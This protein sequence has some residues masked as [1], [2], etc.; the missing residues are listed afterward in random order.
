MIA[1]MSAEASDT[2][3]EVPNASTVLA[4]VST[5]KFVVEKVPSESW[6]AL[7]AMRIVGSTRKATT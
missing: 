5:E 3:R 2:S 4:S 7:T 6:K 1:L